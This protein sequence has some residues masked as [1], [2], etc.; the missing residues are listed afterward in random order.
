MESS[1]VVLFLNVVLGYTCTCLAGLPDIK[2]D[3]VQDKE[4]YLREDGHKAQA[5]ADLNELYTITQN[6]KHEI[7]DLKNNFDQERR[8]TTQLVKNLQSELKE[9]KERQHMQEIS[10][11]EDEL[12][13]VRKT[14]ADVNKL[15]ELSRSK[16]KMMALEV[17]T[18]KQ[19]CQTLT[20]RFCIQTYWWP[21][22]AYFDKQLIQIS[23]I[24]WYLVTNKLTPS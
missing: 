20:G 8:E 14:M 10:Q 13:E 11:I 6:L 9:L 18:L 1:T 3:T 15:E 4:Y 7:L 23:L 17:E 5:A 2:K 19:R 24:D 12:D 22:N 21:L 16:E